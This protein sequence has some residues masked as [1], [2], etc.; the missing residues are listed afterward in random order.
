MISS[1]ISNRVAFILLSP[2]LK[3]LPMLCKFRIFDLFGDANITLWRFL[4]LIPVEKVPYDAI[5]IA[6]SSFSVI[7]RT[8]SL[9]SVSTPPWTKKHF[10]FSSLLLFM[11]SNRGSPCVSTLVYNMSVFPFWS[12]VKFLM[13]K[14]IHSYY[15]RESRHMD[16]LCLIS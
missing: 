7:L 10:L 15:I 1:A 11:R 8:S 5:M 9:S 2:F 12:R 16:S 6:L 3:T 4:I 14:E 13:K